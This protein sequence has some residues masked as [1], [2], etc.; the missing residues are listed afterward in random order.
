MDSAEC[1]FRGELAVRKKGPNDFI[2]RVDLEI[3]ERLCGVLPKLLEKSQVI[4]EERKSA[5]TADPYLWIIDPIDGTNSLVYGFPLYAVSIGLVLEKK[6]VLGVVYLPALG[7]LFSAA[8]G[9]G[10]FLENTLIPG[11]AKKPIRVNNDDSLDKALV[12]AETDPYFDRGKNP[13][14]ELIRLVYERCVDLRISGSAAVDYSFIAAGRAGAHF[15]R[16]LN[17][18]DYAGGSAILLEAGGSFSLWDGSPMPF[19]GKHSSLATNGTLHGEM[20]EII[21]SFLS[22]SPSAVP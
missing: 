16:H 11:G 21:G 20:L 19:E 4:S 8:S 14:M 10:A 7:E 6:P 2:T 1:L 15:C 3:S 18:W 17:P 13:S 12:M 5:L 22:A 9:C